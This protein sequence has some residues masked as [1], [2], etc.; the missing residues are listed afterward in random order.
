MGR[1]RNRYEIIRVISFN[2]RSGAVAST[3]RVQSV[4]EAHQSLRDGHTRVLY[5]RGSCWATASS[6]VIESTVSQGM[7]KVCHSTVAHH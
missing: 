3:L 7:R 1:W 2:S 6:N 5:H 4:I